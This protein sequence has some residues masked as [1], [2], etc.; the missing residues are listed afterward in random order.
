MITD[1]IL[2][3]PEN[4]RK[5]RFSGVFKAYKMGIFSRNDLIYH[6]LSNL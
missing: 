2:D 4:T 1:P 3:P 5:Q 6:I